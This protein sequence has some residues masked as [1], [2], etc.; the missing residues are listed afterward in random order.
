VNTGVEITPMMLYAFKP[1][2][3]ET[4][5][6]IDSLND[7]RAYVATNL[8]RIKADG[9]DEGMR[10]A[11]SIAVDAWKYWEHL[12]LEDLEA[13]VKEEAQRIGVPVSK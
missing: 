5:I 11:H 8:E 4:I 12:S 3:W 2:S 13:M 7:A 6:V 10:S 1:T 9:D